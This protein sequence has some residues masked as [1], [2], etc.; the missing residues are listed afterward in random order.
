VVAS[1]GRAKTHQQPKKSKNVQVV[2]KT[3]RKALVCIAKQAGSVRPDLKVR[4]GAVLL[5]DWI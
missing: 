4:I 5:L 2:K 3:A 1:Y